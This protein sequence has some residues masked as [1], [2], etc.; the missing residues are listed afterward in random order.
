[1]LS[2]SRK[3]QVPITSEELSVRFGT[4]AGGGD[5]I[6]VRKSNNLREIQSASSLE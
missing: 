6:C 3:F 1:L 4:P 2:K 5:L